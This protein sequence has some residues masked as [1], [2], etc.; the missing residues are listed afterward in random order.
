[1]LLN[2]KQSREQQASGGFYF[3]QRATE[4][5]AGEKNH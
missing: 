3:W 4:L 1:V 5:S 2:H